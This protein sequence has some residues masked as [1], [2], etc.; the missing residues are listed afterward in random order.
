MTIKVERYTKN[1][2]TS[3]LRYGFGGGRYFVSLDDVV[4]AQGTSYRG[5]WPVGLEARTMLRVT[6]WEAVK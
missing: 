1:G 4:L 6:G 3:S 2:I 5:V